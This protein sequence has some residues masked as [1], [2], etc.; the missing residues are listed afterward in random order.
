MPHPSR[1]G[2]SASGDLDGG[3][4]AWSNTARARWVLCPVPKQMA[5]TNQTRTERILTRRKANYASVGRIPS[6]SGGQNGVL[7]PAS[8][9][10][11]DFRL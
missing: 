3:S 7:V 1:S 11:G 5:P 8:A 10:N 4:T 6:S 9:P 2:M